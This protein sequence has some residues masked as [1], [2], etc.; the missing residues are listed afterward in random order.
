MLLA[1]ILGVGGAH[2]HCLF[3]VILGGGV[4]FINWKEKKKRKIFV[5]I[6][7]GVVSAVERVVIF[8]SLVFFPSILSD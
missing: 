3:V 6:V 1:C 4:L 7:T 2:K 8:L 5:F